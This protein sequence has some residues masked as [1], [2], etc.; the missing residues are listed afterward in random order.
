MQENCL[1]LV[2]FNYQ[3]TFF[4][5]VKEQVLTYWRVLLKNDVI[6]DWNT[7]YTNDFKLDKYR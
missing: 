5:K 3:R 4:F 1:A 2:K 7:E 6:F